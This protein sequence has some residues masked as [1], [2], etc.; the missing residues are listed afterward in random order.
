MDGGSEVTL[1]CLCV[2]LAGRE[3]PVPG[4]GGAAGPLSGSGSGDDCV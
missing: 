3:P 2:R 1:A 4:P